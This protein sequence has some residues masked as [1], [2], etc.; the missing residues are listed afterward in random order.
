MKN[1]VQRTYGEFRFGLDEMRC[2]ICGRLP[3]KGFTAML[4]EKARSEGMMAC[5]MHGPVKAEIVVALR[6]AEG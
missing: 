2:A 1:R 4:S 5:E 3:H 6:C